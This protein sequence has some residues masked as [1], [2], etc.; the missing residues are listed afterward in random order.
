MGRLFIF[1][2]GGTGARVLRSFTMMLAAGIDGLDSNTTIVPIIIDCDATNGDKTRAI[3]ALKNYRQIH[4]GLYD[5]AHVYDCHFF[6]T[7]MASLGELCHDNTIC[8]D[9]Q[10]NLGVPTNSGMTFADYINLGGIIANPN[11]RIADPFIQALYDDS[12]END[13]NAEL[14]LPLDMGFKGNP[15]IGSV[16]FDKLNDTPEFKAFLTQYN[17]AHDKV[18]VIASI[19]GGTGAS[20]L[21]KIINI[22]PTSS[23]SSALVMMPYFDLG[24]PTDPNDTGA[25]NHHIFKAKSAAALGYYQ[26]T[27]N[28]KA[29]AIYYV[30]DRK[31]DSI[32]YHEGN[33]AQKNTA[34]PAEFMAASAIVHFLKSGIKATDHQAYEY[35]ITN[36]REGAEMRIYDF[37]RQSRNQ[38]IDNLATFAIAM[39]FYRDRVIG[40]RGQVPSNTAF[41]SG[42]N[43]GSKINTGIHES[44]CNFL[45]NPDYGFYQWLDELSNS[46]KHHRHS[47]K[48]FEMVTA[49]DDDCKK[50]FPDVAIKNPLI[51]KSPIDDQSIISE[52]NNF[53]S[54]TSNHSDKTFFKGL[55]DIAA[56]AYKTI[57]IKGLLKGDGTDARYAFSHVNN[58]HP[59]DGW[60][61]VA[62]FDGNALEILDDGH[63]SD[64]KIAT[65][66]PTMFARM[67]FFKSAFERVASNRN[68]NTLQHRVVSDCLDMLELIFQNGGNPNLEIKPVTLAKM[69]TNL[70]PISDKLADSI[71]N[72]LNAS[73]AA[74]HALPT[75][76][77]FFWKGISAHNG[78]THSVLIGGTSPFTLAFMSPNFKR[79][80]NRLGFN[81]QRL[82]GSTM[83][84]ED[85]PKSIDK[86]NVAFKNMLCHYYSAYHAGMAQGIAT[87]LNQYIVDTH[88]IVPATPFLSSYT[89][90]D[91]NHD[92]TGALVSVNTL[93]IVY[94]KVKPANDYK[95]KPTRTVAGD[96][97]LVLNANGVPGLQYV[98]TAQWNSIS[99]QIN[100]ADREK[101]IKDRTL[102]GYDGI[103]Y[104]YLTTFDF[105][106]DKIVRIS[107]NIDASKF[108]T[109]CTDTDGSSYLL[110]LKRKFFEYFNVE[111]ID[112]IVKVS[113]DGSNVKISLNIPI[114]GGTISLS[115]TYSSNDILSGRSNDLMLGFFPFYK[116]SNRPDLD[117]YAILESKFSNSA[118]QG[119]NFYSINDINTPTG[120]IEG[121]RT[122]AM[123]TLPST[124]YYFVPQSFDL[125][126]C[127]Y[128]MYNALIVPK[129][130]SISI[131]PAGHDYTVAID[132]G[133]TNTYI[134]YAQ[135]G[136]PPNTLT[137]GQ[138]TNQVVFLGTAMGEFDKMK[139]FYNRE[140]APQA[141]GNGSYANF[142]T[143]TATCEVDGWNPSTAKLFSDISVGFNINREQVPQNVNFKYHTDIKWSLERNPGNNVA[144]KRIEEYCLELLWIIKNQIIH[145]GGKLPFTLCLSFPDSMTTQ[146]SFIQAWQNAANKLGLELNA[147][148]VDIVIQSHSESVAPYYSFPNF[149]G[150]NNFVNIDIGGGTTDILIVNWTT[151]AAGQPVANAYRNSIRFAA[152][153][154]WGDGV[155]IAA[156]APKDNGFMNSIKAQIK[157][158]NNLDYVCKI[159]PDSADIM[160]YLF[161]LP[162]LHATSKIQAN[163]TLRTLLTV[164]YAA[165]IMHVSRLINKANIEIP[166]K[167][168]FTGMGSKY[169]DIISGNDDA[170]L[171]TFTQ[172]LLES[173][174]GKNAIFYNL[175]KN[176]IIEGSVQVNSKE[177]AAKGIL[178]KNLY[179]GPYQI[180]ITNEI[181]DLGIDTTIDGIT[182]GGI[183][184]AIT[185]K[186]LASYNK[187]L[188]SLTTTE[189]TNKVY[190]LFGFI[191]D[192]SVIDMLK[193]VNILLDFNMVKN[194]YNPR[195]PIK[196]DLVLFIFKHA[197]Y[198]VS[199]EIFLKSKEK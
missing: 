30:A 3:E 89:Q 165:I 31:S 2:I 105:I 92:G 123:S 84:N 68:G 67:Y 198:E 174:T 130:E 136:N 15:N 23:I 140:F 186:V 182:Y 57:N 97:P 175:A 173:F 25:I 191:F 72:E 85:D 52:L 178:M 100:D 164:H 121:D 110:P 147:P 51:G 1:A 161:S 154:L 43:L 39:K 195:T 78:Q 60:N 53:N 14:N 35:C 160:S 64:G 63:A 69:I 114:E 82:D 176:D 98:G 17:P 99:Y 190:N 54:K 166:G 177:V 48:M 146:H 41:F 42:F 22:L 26:D 118:V 104:P 119:I 156:L 180:G 4:N 5:D 29:N 77:L 83:F 139:D 70:N 13:K 155:Q 8:P 79:E 168:T 76:Y 135:A 107:Y 141:I 59:S 111:D 9:F 193:R 142:P 40:D 86:R 49:G 10:I 132:L 158:N 152:N 117:K 62:F 66:I 19:F 181:V 18:F 131:N 122:N 115:R 199:K 88:A 171:Q 124:K 46:N 7:K 75:M 50:I 169:I 159:M 189:F 34:H 73:P 170:R 80:I 113:K 44:I 47:I 90:V 183:N 96:M 108:Y 133:T 197:I 134:A 125:I 172:F 116:V 33:A 93:P 157:N 74:L 58:T 194:S 187:F 81:F 185:D 143:K 144:I 188:D 148:N 94:Q 150:G 128:G 61:P 95:I 103:K 179:A 32:D 112:H 151:D 137:F 145:E 91:L 102:P 126:E 37:S 149:I 71:Q 129:M 196:E 21:P 153:D 162:H 11:A 65:S 27:I 55:K 109:A 12:P 45:K 6:M 167:M 184:N 16:V 28:N 87:Y 24:T 163:E 120:A 106:E 38:F 56:K 36:D 192:T 101:D 20:G 127:N 138:E